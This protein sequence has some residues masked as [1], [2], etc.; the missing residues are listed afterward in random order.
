[1]DLDVFCGEIDRGEFDLEVGPD[2]L[3]EAH[4]LLVDP[5][6]MRNAIVAYLA[7]MWHEILEAEWKRNQTFLRQVVA[8]FQDRFSNCSGRGAYEA[9]RSVTGRDV[10]G[11]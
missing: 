3:A 8:A 10:S 1:M 2:L 5:P 11:T 9:I 6:A 4:A 7:T